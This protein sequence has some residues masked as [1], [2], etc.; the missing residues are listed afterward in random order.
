MW[1]DELDSGRLKVRVE[2]LRCVKT[3]TLEIFVVCSI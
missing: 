2:A 1:G 3:K